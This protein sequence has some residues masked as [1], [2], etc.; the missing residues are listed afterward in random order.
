M[1]N[2]KL[3]QDIYLYKKAI[4]LLEILDYQDIIINK[5]LSISELWAS[6]KV[7]E[8]FN[9]YVN[10]IEYVRKVKADNYDLIVTKEKLVAENVRLMQIVA[11]LRDSQS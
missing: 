4:S 8:L 5:K 7:R 2:Q 11:N 1:A 10:L 6:K 9:A 3:E